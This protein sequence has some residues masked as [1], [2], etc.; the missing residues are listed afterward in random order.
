MM[1]NKRLSKPPYVP[2]KQAN[3]SGVFLTIT[4]KFPGFDTP[5]ALCNPVHT[6][7]KLRIHFRD[8]VPQMRLLIRFDNDQAL[9]SSINEYLTEAGE[10]LV[11]MRLG[12]AHERPE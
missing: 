7:R 3:T 6:S 4:L 5:R 9:L 12:N 2:N 10:W 1:G 11:T 8:I